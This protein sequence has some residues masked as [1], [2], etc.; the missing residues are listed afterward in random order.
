MQLPEASAS[1]QWL[2][3]LH[4]CFL[5]MFAIVRCMQSDILQVLV[6][7]PKF[8]E[9]TALGAALA[10]GLTVG[11]WDENFVLKHPSAEN[12]STFRPSVSKE[13]AAKRFR[14]WQKAVSRCLDLADLAT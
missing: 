3:H 8:Q 7:R 10:A 13:D 4:L 9:T 1:A 6:Q 12:Y 14:H 2:D 11:L 5:T